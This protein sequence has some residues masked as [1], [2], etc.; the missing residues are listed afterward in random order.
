MKS[1]FERM[2]ELAD[3]VFDAR[4]DVSQIQVNETVLEH[5]QQIH[6]ACVSSEENEAGPVAWMLLIPTTQ[7][8]MD[9]FLAGSVT[10]LQL[11]E[12]TPLHTSY[13]A[14]Y[15]CSAMVLPEFQRQGIARRLLM[16]AVTAIRQEHPIKSLFAWTFSNEGLLL[17]QSVSKEVELPLYIKSV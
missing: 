14:L 12:Q 1:N 5:L 2:L 11:Y 13:E 10:E 9:Q 16:D 4:S 15:V 8:L 3:A 6:P 17:A 7:T